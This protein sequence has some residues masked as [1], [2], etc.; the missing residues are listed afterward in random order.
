MYRSQCVARVPDLD[1]VRCGG[2]VL[3]HER[4]QTHGDHV[5]AVVVVRLKVNVLLGHRYR[6]VTEVL[7]DLVQRH[8]PRASCDR[9]CA[10]ARAAA[11]GVHARSL[12]LLLHQK[13]P[14]LPHD[15]EGRL[16][17]AEAAGGR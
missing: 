7:L 9:T 16:L 2:R 14:Y 13:G 10:S 3:P 5:I 1:T 11:P 17:R 12:G 15:G 8:A 6:R 4:P